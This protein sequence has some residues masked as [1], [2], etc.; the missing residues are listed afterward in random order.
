MVGQNYGGG[1]NYGG[2]KVAYGGLKLKP[3]E[4][5]SEGCVMIE[6]D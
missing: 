1:L 4:R 5:F 2:L 6:E 3:D